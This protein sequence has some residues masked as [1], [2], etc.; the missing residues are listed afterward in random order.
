MNAGRG[1]APKSAQR[2]G[3]VL[4]AQKI[5]A[6]ICRRRAARRSHGGI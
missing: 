4:P 2:I 1:A 3:T 6:E 5:A